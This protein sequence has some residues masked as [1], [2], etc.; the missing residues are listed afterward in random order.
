MRMIEGSRDI[1]TQPDQLSHESL[2]KRVKKIRRQVE[3][4][5]TRELH[6]VDGALS[7]GQGSGYFEGVSRGISKLYQGMP[8]LG[9][10]VALIPMG[11]RGIL[12]SKSFKS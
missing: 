2:P 8:L 7:L 9:M 3:V 6:E 10:G 1:L 12:M 5:A 11:R 4:I